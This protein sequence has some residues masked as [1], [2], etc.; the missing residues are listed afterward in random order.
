MLNDSRAEEAY[1]FATITG[2]GFDNIKLTDSIPLRASQFKKIGFIGSGGRDEVKIG[3]KKY[4]TCAG[5]C[6]KCR[7]NIL[8]QLSG[9]DYVK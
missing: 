3:H 9:E 1:K 6:S 2:L 7:Y 4:I 8:C 5:K